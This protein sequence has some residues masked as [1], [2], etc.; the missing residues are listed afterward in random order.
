[1]LCGCALFLLFSLMIHVSIPASVRAWG[2]GVVSRLLPPGGLS[3]VDWLLLRWLCLSLP[4]LGAVVLMMAC[5]W[6]E[7]L[8][9][10]QLRLL[11]GHPFYI[12]A[13]AAQVSLAGPMG[14]FSFC[15]LLVLFLGLVLLRQG[16]LAACTQ[17]CFLAAL[18]VGLPG[19]L[20]VLWG[21][22]LYV[23]APLVCVLALWILMLAVPFFRRTTR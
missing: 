4:V 16:S 11:A 20:C 7:P 18:A 22:V 21:G 3:P 6:L 15:V 5:G 14:M 1:M 2:R 8:D 23:S 12:E 13:E 9:R 10:E 19:L 17:I